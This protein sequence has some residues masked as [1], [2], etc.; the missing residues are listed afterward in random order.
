MSL[1]SND[2]ATGSNDAT[3]LSKKILVCLQSNISLLLMRTLAQI[4]V[5]FSEKVEFYSERIMGK[6]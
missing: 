1:L 2:N 5:A 6:A 4:L 3:L